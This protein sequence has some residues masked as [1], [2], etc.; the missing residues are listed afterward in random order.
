MGIGRYRVRESSSYPLGAA[1]GT[2]SYTNYWWPYQVTSNPRL[3]DNVQNWPHTTDSCWDQTNPRPYVGGGALRIESEGITSEAQSVKT[4]MYWYGSVSGYDGMIV[5]V[6]K[7]PVYNQRNVSGYYSPLPD[8][9][10][11]ASAESRGP[12]AWNRFRPGKPIYSLG[13]SLGELRDVKKSWVQ[14]RNGVRFLRNLGK[15]APR[16]VIDQ[17]ASQYLG[18]QFGWKQM[19]QDIL[20]TV[21]FHERCK[22]YYDQLLAKNG[23]WHSRGGTLDSETEPSYSVTGD[24]YD[25]IDPHCWMARDPVPTEVLFE[26]GSES[27]VW[28]K[29]R[30][31]YYI[32]PIKDNWQYA[33]FARKAYG[34]SLTPDLAWNLLPWSWLSDWFTNFGDSIGNLTNGVVDDLVSEYA[35]IMKHT[36]HYERMSANVRF[37]TV[38]DRTNNNFW[39]KS[40]SG[41]RSSSLKTRSPAS[42]F[43]FGLTSTDYTLRQ[44][45]ILAALGLTK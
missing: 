1:V 2:D 16:A 38:T 8:V 43:G 26:T 12:E 19:A 22:K 33:D 31:K 17:A 41:E 40:V 35:F 45:A 20:A 27:R 29:G 6:V 44:A 11:M 39:S 23:T 4:D 14:L 10:T 34:I 30:F 13:V 3:P 21:S 18:Y 42:P 37:C 9:S 15:K 28:F 25:V 32:Q 7:A 24:D 36:K 5:G